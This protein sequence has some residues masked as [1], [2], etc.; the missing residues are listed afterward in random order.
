[1]LLQQAYA[2]G[3]RDRVRQMAHGIAGV[4]ANL[5]MPGLRDLALALQQAADEDW[6]RAGGLMAELCAALAMVRQ[7]M[8]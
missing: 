8:D 7:Q 3:Q 1:M 6:A 5:L 4:G 2:A